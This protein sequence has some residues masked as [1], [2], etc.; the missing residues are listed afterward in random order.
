VKR[1]S[2]TTCSEALLKSTEDGGDEA[3]DKADAGEADESK[4]LNPKTLEKSEKWDEIRPIMLS[5]FRSTLHVMSEAKEP[6]LVTFILKSLSK[7]ARYMTPF[8][9]IAESMLKTLTGLWSA[10]LDSSE[11]Y[12][13]FV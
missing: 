9:R 2:D 6:E 7:Y 13:S 1:S 10:L 8:P 11:D 3:D 4:P 12:P 5:F